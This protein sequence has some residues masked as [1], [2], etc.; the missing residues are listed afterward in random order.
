VIAVEAEW[1]LP[2]AALAL[3]AVE[4]VAVAPSDKDVV[5]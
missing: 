1:R 4:P 5:A 3:A 2:L